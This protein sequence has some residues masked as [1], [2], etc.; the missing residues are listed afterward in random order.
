MAT[1]QRGEVLDYGG[2]N[3]LENLTQDV[4]Q[5][6]SLPDVYYRLE[7]LIEKPDSTMEQFANLLATEPDLSARLL[8]LANSAFYSFPAS[9]ESIE[10]AVQIV[11]IRQS[12]ELVLATSIMNTFNQVPLG[13]VNMQSFWEHAVCVGVFARAIS[14]Y[15]KLS[16][17][18]RYYVAGLLHDIGRLMFY[19]KLPQTMHDLML[20][21][22]AKEENLHILEY[23]TL[24]YTHAEA[25][26][27]LL[28]HWRVPD[29]IYLPI[30][31]HHHPGQATDYAEVAAAVHI[32]DVFAVR[33]SIGSSGER[34]ELELQPEA[35][36]ILSIQAPEL[37]ELWNL[38]LDDIHNV[39]NQF[40]LQ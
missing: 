22:E 37:D 30:E 33:H 12:R 19:L 23:E 36:E 10:K 20:Q 2:I 21:R 4:N 32:A 24:G 7:A 3:N 29:A 15:C 17:A 14:H 39:I 5:L 26:A 34:F 35:L 28:N 1:A 13:M 8:S 38:T 40:L 27:S 31:H 16:Q 9:I 25:G 11:G 18:E 6:V